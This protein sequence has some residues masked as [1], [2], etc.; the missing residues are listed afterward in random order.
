MKNS[1]IYLLLG[2][3]IATLIGVTMLTITI[4]GYSRKIDDKVTYIYDQF[5]N[6]EL[7][8]CE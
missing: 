6:T 8:L 2:A 7:E 3:I 5:Y 1:S 4:L